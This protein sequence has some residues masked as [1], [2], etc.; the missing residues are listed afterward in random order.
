MACNSAPS[1]LAYGQSPTLPNL[2]FAP[3]PPFL[4]GHSLSGLHPVLQ[5]KPFFLQ[6]PT[7]PVYFLLFSPVRGPKNPI[8]R[9]VPLHDDQSHIL[10]I[11]MYLF[12]LSTFSCSL[13][14]TRES[15]FF[16]FSFFCLCVPLW[17]AAVLSWPVTPGFHTVLSWAVFLSF[18]LFC[19]PCSLH[20][21]LSRMQPA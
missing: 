8:E 21:G 9:P 20:G 7:A 18:T 13:R 10:N 4:V 6:G 5:F 19:P 12:Y 1:Q 11:S 3:S 15:P 17:W 14:L 16:F 2:P